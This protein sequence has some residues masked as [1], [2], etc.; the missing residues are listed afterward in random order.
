MGLFRRK[1]DEPETAAAG[2][3]DG[4]FELVDAAGD[5]VR[6]SRD[7][8]DEIFTTADEHEMRRHLAIGRLLLDQWVAR[9]PGRTASWVDTG[10]RRAAGRVLP[11]Q[12]D[13]SYEAPSAV[14]T[15]VLGHLKDGATGTRVG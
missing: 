9:D 7:D 3:A 15:Y 12:D 4:V 6:Y 2:A 10:L 5:P 8:F 13:P 14:A 11:A 1:R